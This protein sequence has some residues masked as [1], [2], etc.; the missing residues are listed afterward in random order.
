MKYIVVDFFSN[1]GFP[2][3]LATSNIRKFLDGIFQNNVAD[4]TK[5][6]N[7][8]YIALPFFGPQSEKLKQD[9]LLLLSKYLPTTSFNIILVN[10]FKIG[11]FSSI[12]TNFLACLVRTLLIT[13]SA[14]NVTPNILVQPKD[15]FTCAY[16]I[17]TLGLV[18]VSCPH[19]LALSVNNQRPY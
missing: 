16:R 18:V 6:E 10:N 12:K 13:L 8:R 14:H 19:D 15:T 3:F 5:N 17:N 2:K 1:N 9:I 7:S 4:P 11:S